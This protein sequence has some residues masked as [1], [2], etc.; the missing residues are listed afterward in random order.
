MDTQMANDGPHSTI[1]QITWE[2]HQKRSDGQIDPVVK[3]QGTFVFEISGVSNDDSK[4]KA[5]ELI[6]EI[7]EKVKNTYVNTIGNNQ[8]EPSKTQVRWLGG[9]QPQ[10]PALLSVREIVIGRDGNGT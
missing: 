9:T 5:N 2:T 3:D 4:K 1:F 10:Q 8:T 7:K 6:A